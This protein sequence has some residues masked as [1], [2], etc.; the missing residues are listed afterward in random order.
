MLWCVGSTA[1]QMHAHVTIHLSM[2]SYDCEES[3]NVRRLP[4][5]MVQ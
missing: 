1:T 3:A 2:Q 5:L 4:K